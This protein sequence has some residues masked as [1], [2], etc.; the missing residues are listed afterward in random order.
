M[1][2]ELCQK[3]VLLPQDKTKLARTEKREA[4]EEVNL[5]KEKRTGTIKGCTFANESKQ[6]R[7]LKDL[8]DF[9]SPTI[10]LEDLFS[11]FVIDSHEGRDST[12][13][14]IPAAHLHA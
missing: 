6:K 2:K 8:E 5:I 3:T 1:K 12:T 13:F 11:S 10:S 4:L 14:D 7:I 9:A